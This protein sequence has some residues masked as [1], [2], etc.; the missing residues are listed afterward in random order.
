MAETDYKFEGWLGHSPDSVHGKMEWGSFEPKKWTEDDV[1]IQVTHCG[2]CGS[3]IQFV[4]DL[5][6]TFQAIC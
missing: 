5:L 4:Y 2:I 1:D 3:D 6:A